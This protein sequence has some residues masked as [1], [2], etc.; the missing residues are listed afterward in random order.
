VWS[1]EGSWS[2]VIFKDDQ[3]ALSSDVLV[4]I[5]VKVLIYQ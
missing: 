2:E 3:R 4:G 1:L 5:L